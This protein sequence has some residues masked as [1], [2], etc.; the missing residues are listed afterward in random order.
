MRAWGLCLALAGLTVAGI[1]EA[2]ETPPHQTTEMPESV[3]FS[4]SAGSGL[5]AAWYDAPTTRYG[6]GVLGDAIEAGALYAYAEAAGTD[7]DVIGLVLDPDYVFEDVAPRLADL[8]GDGV[9]EIIAVRSSLSRGAQLAVYGNAGDGSS[10]ALLAATPFIGQPNRWLAPVGAADLDGDGWVEIAYID[11][12]HLARILRVW[13]YQAG[14][15]EEV[16]TLGGLTNHRIGEAFISGGIRA[17]GADPEMIV[18]STDWSRLIAARFDG[19]Q[20]LTRD[21]G[22]WSDASAAAALDC[23]GN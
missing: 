22:P 3:V 6:H 15:L 8:D 17:C 7:C 14:A 4:G 2:C 9:N 5:W 10:L 16:A 23:A 20:I 11:R 18:A 21:L 13:R 1:A 19:Q 12:P